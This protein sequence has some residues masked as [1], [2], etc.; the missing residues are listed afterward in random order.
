MDLGSGVLLAFNSAFIFR[1][2]IF[3]DAGP[4]DF[5]AAQSFHAIGLLV[6]GM[7]LVHSSV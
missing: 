4:P 7:K 6:G 1:L 2:N 3:A 5:L